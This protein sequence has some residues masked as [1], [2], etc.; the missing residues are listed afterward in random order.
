MTKVGSIKIAEEISTIQRI[1]STSSLIGTVEGKIG[2]VVV[3]PEG[4]F[5]H[6]KAIE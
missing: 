6:L 1:D 2:K 5:E 3:V 4:R